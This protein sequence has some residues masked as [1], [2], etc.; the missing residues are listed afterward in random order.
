MATLQH[1]PRLTSDLSYLLILIFVGGGVFLGL[2]RNHRL[3]R[4]RFSIIPLVLI[5]LWL[6]GVILGLW[7][8]VS[9]SLVFRN[10]A[11]MSLFLSTMSSSYFLRHSS[12]YSRGCIM[13]ALSRCPGRTLRFPDRG[14]QGSRGGDQLHRHPL[15]LFLGS[16]VA[17]AVMFS[18]TS[19]SVI[20]G[21]FRITHLFF[22]MAIFWAIFLSGSR[23]YYLA[24]FLTML[25][26]VICLAASTPQ[27]FLRAAGLGLGYALFA[28]FLLAIS[29]G[30]KMAL[31]PSSS[32]SPWK[33]TS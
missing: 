19:R 12:R 11:A 5:G 4:D 18:L 13:L 16:L 29:T 7:N 8:G 25:I 15:S 22:G 24:L 3:D 6:Y 30:P 10:F 20:T 28:I 17:S 2:R 33:S 9:P 27:R 32:P 14:D 26:L 21:S 1:D 23:A 31:A